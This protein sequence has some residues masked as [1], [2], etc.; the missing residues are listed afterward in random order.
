MK[1]VVIVTGGNKGLG[2]ALI[3]LALKD[4]DSVIISISRDLHIEHVSISNQKLIL[5]KTD[6]S[7]P[8]SDEILNTIDKVISKESLLYVFNNAGIVLP[9]NK[10]GNFVKSE[11]DISIAV[12]ILYPVNLINALLDRYENLKMIIVNIS[13]GAGRKP[14]SHWS[15]YGAAKS[16]MIM[17]FDIIK[18]ESKENLIVHSIDPGVLDTQMQENIRKSAFPKQED[19]IAFKNNDALITPL[20]AAINIF[21]TINF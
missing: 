10:V 4:N 8:F 15:L 18:E 2:K 20:E 7:Q 19:F 17:F 11:I 21:K 5:V 12:N 6:L 16:Y 3:D 14:I 13:S 9:I 1:K